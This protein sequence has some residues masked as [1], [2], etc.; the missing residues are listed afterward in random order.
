MAE[1]MKKDLNEVYEDEIDL[2][3]LLN[4][5]LKHKFKIILFS[6]FVT[7]LTLIYVLSIPNSYKSYVVLSPQSSSSKVSGGLSSLASLAG[8]NL[9][10]GDSKDPSIMLSTT[11]DDYNFNKYVI[12]KYNLLDILDKKENLVFAFGIDSIYNFLNT[13]QNKKMQMHS[14]ISKLKTVLSISSDKK[15][16]MINLNAELNDRFLAKK[17]VDIYLIEM[18]Y[19]IRQFDMKE[20]ENQIKYYKKELSLSY[21]VSLK[22]QL[23]KSLSALYQKKVF[24]QANEYYLVSK[25]IDSRVAHIKEKTKPKR[26]LILVVSFVSSLILGIFLVFFLEF[27]KNSKNEENS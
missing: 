7:L 12:K 18:I 15:T 13:G 2:K 16:G 25:V 20:I 6:F 27:I 3:E 23:S 4:T 5:V 21:D 22:E 17:L 24:S 1:L 14:A 11:L 19:K 9:G 8:V 10:G 26:A